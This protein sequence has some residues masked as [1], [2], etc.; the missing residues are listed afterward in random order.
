ML[1]H[2]TQKN[3]H[4]LSDGGED[5]AAVGVQGWRGA[6]AHHQLRGQEEAPGE[7][8]LQPPGLQKGRVG[9]ADHTGCRQLVFF[10]ISTRV[11]TT[12]HHVIFAAK[13]PVD[14]TQYGPC[15][16]SDTPECQ[17]YEKVY[18]QLSEKWYPPKGFALT[19][20]TSPELGK[21]VGLL[22]SPRV[23]SSYWLHR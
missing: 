23:F 22:H 21:K 14:D 19:R 17:P 15:N 18:V 16:Q 7:L 4:L 11:G 12:F 20:L 10:T 3:N 9:H 2:Q 5:A 6:R 8:L 13:A 1:F